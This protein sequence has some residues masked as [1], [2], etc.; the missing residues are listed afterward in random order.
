MKKSQ[1]RKKVNNSKTKRKIKLNKAKGVNKTFRNKPFN[2]RNSTLKNQKGGTTQEEYD[3][4]VGP[5]GLNFRGMPPDSWTIER[6]P[7][8]NMRPSQFQDY[9]QRINTMINDRQR[10]P[11]QISLA[12]Q[13]R[14]RLRTA[15]AKA[16]EL[17]PQ[18][19]EHYSRNDPNIIRAQERQR[20]DSAG[21]GTITEAEA[22]TQRAANNAA[23]RGALTDAELPNPF[24]FEG[25]L[26]IGAAAEAA[27]FDASGEG[28][29]T[30]ASGSLG[31]TAAVAASGLSGDGP[32]PPPPPPPP[33]VRRVA[34]PPDSSSDS[35]DPA[36]APAP[37]EQAEP[38]D[39]I[40]IT[41]SAPPGT[42]SNATG[43]V[44]LPDRNSINVET[45][46]ADLIN[47]VSS[48]ITTV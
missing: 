47:S 46:L 48:E 39:Q 11:D 14:T 18:L 9:R 5:T 12:G 36:L 6:N 10:G 44:I 26:G 4:I 13:R 17:Q 22:A 20:N 38:N 2:L 31:P 24:S 21:R 23:G 41:I 16:L 3:D 40:T 27:S 42:I 1:K 29:G 33:I 32:S 25:P 7:F 19:I 28:E 15:L 43:G 30:A 45:T 8:L 37:P 35:M 34:S